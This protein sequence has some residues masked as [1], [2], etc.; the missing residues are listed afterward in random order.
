M[1][2]IVALVRIFKSLGDS[3]RLAILNS[4]S[5]ESMPVSR[6]A[7]EVGIT[8]SLASH[9]LKLLERE[10]LVI[11]KREGKNVKYRLNEIGIDDLII[12]F[13]EFLDISMEMGNIPKF[14]KTHTT[15]TKKQ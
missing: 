14:L 11:R 12:S 3:G 8:S 15:E 1:K 5:K 7:E 6:I 2:S 10:G 9:H 13:Y 4:V